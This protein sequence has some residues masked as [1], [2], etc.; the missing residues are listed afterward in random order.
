[1]QALPHTTQAQI[2]IRVTRNARN[3]HAYYSFDYTYY[4]QNNI[5]VN[6]KKTLDGKLK[7]SINRY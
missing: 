3:M 5:S 4:N 2:R 1:M 7:F 6:T